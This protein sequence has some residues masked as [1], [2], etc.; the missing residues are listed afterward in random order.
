MWVVML[1]QG[2][3]QDKRL[4]EEPLAQASGLY[5]TPKNS[6]QTKIDVNHM[7]LYTGECQSSGDNSDLM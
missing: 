6:R 7:R 4:R 2:K 3:P 5:Q 1:I